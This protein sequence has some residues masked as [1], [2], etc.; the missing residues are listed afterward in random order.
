M[1]NERETHFK[2]KRQ[3][4]NV[5]VDA[6]PNT[7]KEKAN[8]RTICFSFVVSPP[9]S[10][11]LVFIFERRP[12]KCDSNLSRPLVA[13]SKIE[14]SQKGEADFEG[15]G[16]DLALHALL[17]NAKDNTSWFKGVNSNKHE[18]KNRKPS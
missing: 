12:R 9:S 13:E 2:G 1:V 6:G 5:R 4:N 11:Q 16:Y 10:S 14:A 17:S 15:Q 18:A 8:R 3:L 7:E